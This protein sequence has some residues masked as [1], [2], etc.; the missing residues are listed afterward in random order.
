MTPWCG[1]VQANG[2]GAWPRKQA[3]PAGRGP[4]LE[5][6]PTV[7]P[8]GPTPRPRVEALRKAVLIS[9]LPARACL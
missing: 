1:L 9:S 3:P 4:E 6:P 8:E 5:L 2:T 7:G